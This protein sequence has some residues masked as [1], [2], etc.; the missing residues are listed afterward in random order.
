MTNP[1][2]VVPFETT[3]DPKETRIDDPALVDTPYDSKSSRCFSD[4]HGRAI[5]GIWEAGPHLSK[6]NLLNSMMGADDY[7]ISALFTFAALPL[8]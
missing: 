5:S 4:A 1:E 8:Y 3:S 7:I 2:F 6:A